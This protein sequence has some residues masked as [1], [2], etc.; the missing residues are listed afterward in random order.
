MCTLQTGLVSEA[1]TLEVGLLE[2]RVPLEAW[3]TAG[4]HIGVVA[5]HHRVRLRRVLCF[6]ERVE[7]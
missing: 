6:L 5:R 2:A 1:I 3:G 7:C 4:G